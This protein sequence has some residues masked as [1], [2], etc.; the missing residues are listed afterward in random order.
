VTR[1]GQLERSSHDRERSGG[2]R[3]RKSRRQ[4]ELLLLFEFRIRQVDDNKVIRFSLKHDK[5]KDFDVEKGQYRVKETDLPKGCR[6]D[7]IKVDGPYE[8]I[9]LDSGVAVVKVREDQ[10][11]TVTF[12][13]K[14][15]KDK[16]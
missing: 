14:C 9:N 11:T 3:S 8:R 5:C 6:V 16:H 13:D 12:V 10:T 1:C 7:D 2:G 4:G 15:K